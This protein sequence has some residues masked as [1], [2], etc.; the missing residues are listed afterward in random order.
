M[1]I[2]K[3]LADIK[4][5]KHQWVLR[6]PIASMSHED[7]AWFVTTLQQLDF[8]DANEGCRIVGHKYQLLF[9]INISYDLVQ[10]LAASFYDAQIM[11]V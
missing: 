11:K 8:L 3:F 4:R 9:N 10:D 2:E 7:M 1:N 5:N 6:I